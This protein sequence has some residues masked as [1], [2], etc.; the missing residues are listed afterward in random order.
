MS[1]ALEMRSPDEVMS[2]A[3]LGAAHQTRLSFLR[4]MLRRLTREGWVIDRP[5]FEIDDK[6]FGTA[7]YR[8]KGPE[9]TYSLVCF[10]IDL[11]DDMRTDRVIAVAWDT[12]YAL[13]DGEPTAAD[14][15]RLR[16]N[17]PK[18]EAGRF[19]EK[20]LVLSRANKSMRLFARVVDALAAGR[21]PDAVEI[22]EVGYLMRTTA[23]Y[24]NGKLGMADRDVIRDRAELAGPFQ[25][26]MLTVWLIRTFTVDLVEHVARARAPETA[27]PLEP[28]LRRR[29]GVGNATGLG[30]APFLVRHPGLTGRWAAARETALARVRAIERASEAAKARFPQVLGLARR[31]V[32]AWVT[33]DPVQKAEI[34][35]LARDL[36]LIERRVEEGA[37]EEDHPFD[38]L[39][40][41]SEW[42]LGLEGQEY[43]VTLAIEPHGDLV[44]DLAD[45]MAFDEEST[46]RIDGGMPLGTLRQHIAKAY[47]WVSRHDYRTPE[48]QAR[49][50]YYS[51]D[52]LE[53]RLGERF[54][55]PGAELEQPLGIGRDVQALAVAAA[56]VNPEITVG[57]YLA[58]HPEH[59]HLVRRIQASAALPYAEIHDNVL[60]ARMRPVDILRWKLAFFGATRFDPRSDRWLR[61]TLFQGAPFPEEL[62]AMKSE[63]WV[64]GAAA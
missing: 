49:F 57:A 62:Q 35:A 50:W 38:K 31:A 17:V 13:F 4:T 51:E 63:N 54:E 1:D 45:E 60:G 48:G 7:V 64:Y 27:V 42:A 32:S 34:A 55:E 58:D 21:Q 47:R 36:E 5:V 44:D 59:R 20:E 28:S 46:F 19:T 6:G 2:L 56:L 10:S 37:L 23:V 8:A 16:D 25:A 24:G 26:E 3:R 30:M 43:L 41:W 61:I 40:C 9:R 53:P 22:E 18:Q 15:A 39:I 33:S 29:F 11:P 52:K 14:I 12:S